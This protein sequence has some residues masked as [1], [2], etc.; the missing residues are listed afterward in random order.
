MESVATRYRCAVG[1]C[2]VCSPGFATLKAPTGNLQ[3]MTTVWTNKPTGN[4]QKMMMV[5]IIWWMVLTQAETEQGLTMLPLMPENNVWVTLAHACRC[6]PRSAARP[7]DCPG[8]SGLVP[9]MCSES[10]LFQARVRLES[11]TD[12]PEAESDWLVTTGPPPALPF[13]FPRI[14]QR[15]QLALPLLLLPLVLRTDSPVSPGTGGT[16]KTGIQARSLGYIS[17]VCFCFD[18]SFTAVTC[19]VSELPSRWIARAISRQPEA[20]QSRDR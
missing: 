6:L 18:D 9:A 16:K 19:R 5:W 11:S 14:K 10:P 17:T 1:T 8:M 3:K 12:S 2:K 4:L 13:P 20:F 15:S 7:R